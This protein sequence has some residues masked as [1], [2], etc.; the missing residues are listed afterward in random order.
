MKVAV[1]GGGVAG[2]SAAIALKQNGFEVE[3]YERNSSTTDIGAGIVCWP[4]ASFVLDD[5]GILDQV[6]SVSGMPP[7]MKRMTQRGES[8]GSLDIKQLNRLMGYPSF[9]I[10]RSELMS[11]L[12]RRM[13]ALDISLQYGCMATAIEPIEKGKTQ[14]CFDNGE[15]LIADLVIGAEGRMNSMTRQYVHGDNRP[16][17]Q[18]FINWIGVYES[19]DRRFSDLSVFDYWGLGERFGIVPIT[20]RK[21]YWAG[22]VVSTKT[23]NRNPATYKDDLT[24][25]FEGWPDPITA[26]IKGTPQSRINKIY[27]HD[28]EPVDVWHRDNVLLIGDAAHAPLPTS[29]QGACQALEDAWH[30]VQCLKTGQPLQAV[31]ERFTDIRASK[32]TGITLGARKLA[33]SIFNTDP[34]YCSERNQNSLRTDYRAVVEGMAKG[35]ATGLPIG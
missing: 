25:L 32:T 1:L 35:W 4:N 23:G 8:L 28:L 9:S 27:V 30:L 29:G 18:G 33:S 14:L 22:G 3:V 10:L 7:M 6:A 12:L 5:L 34:D 16:V 19:D 20:D 26:I 2:L 13:A 31:L 15:S 17:Y 24:A 11:L 21:A